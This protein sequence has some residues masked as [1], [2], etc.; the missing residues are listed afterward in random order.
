[1]G[2]Q[3]TR[4]V[5]QLQSS[6]KRHR[7]ILLGLTGGIANGKSTVAAM[8]AE[9]GAKWFDFD[10]LAREVVEPGKPAWKDIV[11]FFGERVHAADQSLNRQAVSE[12][13]F[14]YPG[15][16]KVLEEITHPRI[17]EEFSRRIQQSGEKSPGE[18]ILADIPLLVELDLGH[19]FH[20]VLL[21][22][23]PEKLQIER[24]A[25]R[26]RIDR[27]QAASLVQAQISIEKKRE[28]ADVI[29]DNSQSLDRTRAQVER[30]WKEIQI[31]LVSPAS[32]SADI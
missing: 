28:Y 9:L 6:V 5:E 15:K 4:A 7:M 10:L 12:I 23:V 20:R 22:Y 30:I 8:F 29:I 16:R 14:Q 27:E 1:M 21:V 26:N 11:D 25:R 31:L 3:V 32:G 13:V 24:L 18:A 19:L 17:F 2:K